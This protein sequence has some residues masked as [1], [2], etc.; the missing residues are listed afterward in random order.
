MGGRATIAAQI[1]AGRRV[2]ITGHRLRSGAGEQNE[3]LLIHSL[4]N[5]GRQHSI[6]SGRLASTSL[7]LIATSNTAPRITSGELTSTRKEASMKRRSSSI[8][9]RSM[10]FLPLKHIPSVAGPTHFKATM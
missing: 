3:T 10:H 4:D 8:P 7:W 5:T 1:T 9:T 2:H 6:A